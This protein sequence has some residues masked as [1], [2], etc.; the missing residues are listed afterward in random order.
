M[1]R[2]KSLNDFD[3]YE[4]KILLR[5]DI[6]APIDPDTGKIADRTR[7]EKSL[8]TMVKLRSKGG[9]SNHCTPG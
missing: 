9:H 4:K 3:L 7:L 6:N 2:V 1:N 5:L 8:A